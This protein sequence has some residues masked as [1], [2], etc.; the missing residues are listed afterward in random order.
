MRKYMKVSKITKQLIAGLLA[1]VLTLSS[2]QIAYAAPITSEINTEILDYNA[3]IAT[4]GYSNVEMAQSAY[5]AFMKA[6]ESGLTTDLISAYKLIASLT[7]TQLV[8]FFVLRYKD[9]YA[10]HFLDSDFAYFDVDKY[11]LAHPKLVE[12]IE[13]IEDQRKFALDYY[14]NFGIFEGDSSCTSF[15]PILAII[16]QPE[17]VTTA[18]VDTRMPSFE[19]L[20]A[21]HNAYTVAEGVADT[22]EYASSVQERVK[23]DEDYNNLYI[24]KKPVEKTVAIK[25]E[26]SAPTEVPVIPVEEPKEDVVEGANT[27]SDKVDDTPSV[28]VASP[29]LNPEDPLPTSNPGGDRPPVRASHTVNDKKNGE[30]REVIVYLNDDIGSD[31]TAKYT[32][33]I[34]LCG[35]DLEGNDG[36]ATMD[37]LKMMQSKLNT[38]PEKANVVICAGGT[39]SWKNPYMSRGGTDINNYDND[40]KNSI[41]SCKVGYYNLN[42]SALSSAF[43]KPVTY[44]GTTYRTPSEILEKVNLDEIYLNH[45]LLNAVIN[46]DTMPMIGHTYDSVDFTDPWILTSLLDISEAYYK[47]DDYG[48]IIWNH[49]GGVAA[50]I[51]AADKNDNMVNSMGKDHTLLTIDDIQDAIRYSDLY[52]SADINS[53]GKWEDGTTINKLSL[54]GM[55]A[56]L[57]GGLD[58]ALL[59]SDYCKYYVGSGEVAAGGWDYKSIFNTLN[60]SINS[61]VSSGASNIDVKNMLQTISTSYAQGHKNNN[62]KIVQTMAVFDSE[63]VKEE[64]LKIDKLYTA[65]YGMLDVKEDAT[66]EYKA[67]AKELYSILHKAEATSMAYGLNENQA[68]HENYYSYV[69]VKNYLSNLRNFVDRS[70]LS[71]TDKGVITYNIRE[72]LEGEFLLAASLGY[73]NN[74]IF[75]QKNTSGLLSLKDLDASKSDYW[76]KVRLGLPLAG[77]SMYYSEYIAKDDLDS[78]DSKFMTYV[79]NITSALVNGGAKTDDGYGN[80]AVFLSSM[81]DYN[82]SAEEKERIEELTKSIK[83]ADVFNGKNTNGQVGTQYYYSAGINDAYT[84]SYDNAYSSQN[85]YV[86]LHDTMAVVEAMVLNKQTVVAGSTKKNVDIVVSSGKLQPTDLVYTPTSSGIVVAKDELKDI[87]YSYEVRG[88]MVGDNSAKYYRDWATLGVTYDDMVTAVNTKLVEKEYTSD[89]LKIFKGSYATK[90]NSDQYVYGY[91]VFTENIGDA[92]RLDY[93]CSL[94]T[95]ADEDKNLETYEV[96][97]NITGIKFYHYYIENHEYKSLEDNSYEVKNAPVYSTEN[98]HINKILAVLDNSADFTFDSYDQYVFG[99]NKEYYGNPDYVTDAVF[100]GEKAGNVSDFSIIGGEIDMSSKNPALVPDNDSGEP[101]RA[102]DENTVE[103]NEEIVENASELDNVNDEAELDA[104]DSIENIDATNLE[105]ETI[106]SADELSSDDLSAIDKLSEDVISADELTEETSIDEAV[107]PEVIDSM[108]VIESPESTPDDDPTPTDDGDGS[109]EESDD[110]DASIGDEAPAAEG[111]AA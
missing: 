67:R 22:L 73:E 61:A 94:A 63:A 17:A 72:V 24:S 104:I 32:M 15:D 7:P 78:D 101:H 81:Y 12:G 27:P 16:V 2:A 14:L 69:D 42:L 105:T 108:T 23:N 25:E 60:S 31:K 97:E 36:A 52:G 47:A 28:P 5:D 74:I 95:G 110:T 30:S 100:T 98:L 71:P 10:K 80:A 77:I 21:V 84:E 41:N 109:D 33:M 45:D 43:A 51:C 19:T 70:N 90:N 20:E 46:K 9:Y 99:V 40:I 96:A 38:D 54:L 102:V 92:N 49:G 55:D 64:M 66:E 37:I 111:D 79:Q 4:Y 89:K 50:G 48:L 68:L 82:N 93:L 76:K 62:T 65:L 75:D 103:A 57:M 34:Y 6:V 83:Y 18:L 107:I 53:D 56:C 3:R 35:T 87:M 85:P 39:D 29:D 26:V 59:L 8:H 11:I 1:A 44:K 58:D 13:S 91:H 86:D 88:N 106:E